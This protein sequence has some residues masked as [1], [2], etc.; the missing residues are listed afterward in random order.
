[1]RA[2]LFVA[3]L[4]PMLATAT[5]AARAEPA[6]QLG[7]ADRAAIRAAIAAQLAAFAA[8]DGTTAFGYASPSIQRQFGSPASFMEMVRT[9]YMPVYR[10][11]EVS[12]GNLIELRGRPTQLVLLVG[13][14]LSVVTAYYLMERQR[15]GT[16]R[17]DGCI[18]GRAP[19]RAT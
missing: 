14:D 11:R 4:V 17:I 16:W 15:D 9:G 19:D 1:M 5:A 6:A 10:P 13:P 8:D 18:L 12:F 7:D 2:F 3:L